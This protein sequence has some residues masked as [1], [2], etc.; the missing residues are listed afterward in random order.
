MALETGLWALGREPRCQLGVHL[1]ETWSGHVGGVDIAL[2]QPGGPALIELKWD[3]KTL[4]A[5]AWDQI[6][7]AAA[8][9]CGEGSRAFLIAGSPISAGLRGDELLEDGKIDP[10]RLRADY[11]KEFDFW[12][13]D[14]QNH[15]LSAPARWETSLFHSASLEVKAA[16]W[17]IRLA[18]LELT[19]P[20]LVSFGS[21]MP[22]RT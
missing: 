21:P 18:E 20:E 2:D 15:P 13:S 9:H 1:R 5:C 3:P 14:V 22:A 11:A 8:L 16:P 4:A 17:H 19:R 10:L 12:R 7:L 6:K